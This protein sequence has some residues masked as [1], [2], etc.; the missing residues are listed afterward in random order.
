MRTAATILAFV[1]AGAAAGAIGCA[2]AFFGL[3]YLLRFI[4]WMA[5]SDNYMFFMWSGMLIIPAVGIGSFVLGGVWVAVL[6]AKRTRGDS[7]G[8]EVMPKS[9]DEHAG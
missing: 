1:A 2:A 9:A 5:G 6:V 7:G 8:F 3:F 4:C